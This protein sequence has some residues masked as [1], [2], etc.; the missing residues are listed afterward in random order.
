MINS[1]KITNISESGQV[2]NSLGCKCGRWHYVLKNGSMIMSI[3]IK[4]CHPVKVL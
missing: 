4:E 2:C 3:K 1:K